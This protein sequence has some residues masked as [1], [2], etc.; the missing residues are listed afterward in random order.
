MSD[1]K[2]YYYLKLKEN[3][4]DSEEM[5]IL[6]SMKN[7]IEYQNLYM[8]LCLLSLKNEGGLTFK[9]YI[10]YDIHMLSTVLRVNID[11]IKTAIEI[12]G[13]LGLITQID[14]G[15]LYMMDIQ[16]LIG[17]GSS[18]AERKAQYRK[19]IGKDNVP[20]LSGQNP[21]ELE[22][23]TEIETELKTEIETTNKF[24]PP[25]ISEISGYCVEKGYTEI[26]AEYFWNYYQARGW[27]Y[28][29]GQPMKDWKAA[30][31][32]WRKKNYKS[33]FQNNQS[34]AERAKEIKKVL[35]DL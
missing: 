21:P 12:F 13:K 25:S 26:D 32:T 11:T 10:P 14:N 31:Q 29:T 35:G 24:T 6:E 34:P 4:F 28:K 8:K 15:T 27:K 2:K 19:K 16:S 18:E 20:K 3:F 33:K 7:G 5:K 1:N 17:H 30:I 22:L 23:K 9:D